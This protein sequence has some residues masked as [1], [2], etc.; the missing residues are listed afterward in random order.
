VCGR[1]SVSKPREAAERFGFVEWHE[2]RV[3]PRFNVAP[4]QD[5][6]MVVQPPRG[7]RT[8]QLATWGFTPHWL[9][10]GQGRRPPPINARAESLIQS[11]M[12]KEALTARR[13][14]I[15]ADG[16]Y[17]WKSTPGSSARTPMYIRLKGGGLFAFAGLWA[18]GKADTRPTAAIVTTRANDLVAPIHNRMPVILKPEDEGVWLDPEEQDLG[19]LQALLAPLPADRLE[20]YAVAPLVNAFQNE[21]PELIVPTTSKPATLVQA[22]LPL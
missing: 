1:F 12:F 22:Q 9:R 6:L 14:L 7:D 13:C 4:T 10:A 18:P 19:R 3:E 5:I 15:V 8:P 16:F 20:A 17:E 2:V 11:P 21:G